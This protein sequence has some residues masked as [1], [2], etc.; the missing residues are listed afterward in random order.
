[1]VDER[2]TPAAEHGQLIGELRGSIARHTSGETQKRLLAR[3]D[4]LEKSPTVSSFAAHVRA[5]IEE[6]EEEAAAIGPFM[7]RLSN[8]LP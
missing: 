1:M 3:L 6:A 2:K 8:L 5:L 4:Q 7:S